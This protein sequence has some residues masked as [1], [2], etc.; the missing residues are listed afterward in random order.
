MTSLYCINCNKY[1]HYSKKCEHGIISNGIIAIYIDKNININ[2]KK[3]ESFFTINYNKY[4]NGKNDIVNENDNIKFLLMQRKHSLGFG[5]LI[6]GHYDHK[7]IKSINYI[8]K[9]MNIEEIELFKNKSFDEL[10]NYYWNGGGIS[11]DKHREEFNKAKFKFQFIMDNY[12]KDEFETS[13]FT[14]NEWGFPK[15]RREKNE[16][17]FKCAIREFK[18]ETNIDNFLYIIRNNSIK[19]NLI[20]TNQKKYIHNYYISF[21][22]ENINNPNNNEVGDLKLMTINEC[23][24]NIRPYHYEKINIVK[25]LFNILN[26]FINKND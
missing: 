19:E 4:L 18:E 13:E 17:D 23:L 21:I 26:D 1:G 2:Y 24:T 11:K 6:R 3:F 7:D 16:N 9:Q 25:S 12:N 20:G 10:W 8:V 5:E 14:F 22:D 15:G